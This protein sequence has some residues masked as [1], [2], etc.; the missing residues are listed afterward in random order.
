MGTSQSPAERIRRPSRAQADCRRS[1]TS[2]RPSAN[3]NDQ[4]TGREHNHDRS[5]HV[6][7]RD[8]SAITV[9]PRAR[10]S[11]G[12]STV[13][14]RRQADASR[15]GSAARERARRATT[16]V[17]RTRSAADCGKLMNVAFQGPETWKNQWLAG[18]AADARR[19]API[20]DDARRDD[21]HARTLRH[22]HVR[23]RRRILLDRLRLWLRRRHVRLRSRRLRRNVRARLRL[24]T[25][26]R[27]RFG[28]CDSRCCVRR[29]VPGLRRR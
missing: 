9:A 25:E 14:L 4:R 8:P 27:L 28:S 22:R 20:A 16:R 23:L 2:G 17:E 1:R 11:T 3:A 18:I 5:A 7:R 6:Q 10:Q 29:T 19:N 24:R 12:Q 15:Y 26:L 21:A 13:R